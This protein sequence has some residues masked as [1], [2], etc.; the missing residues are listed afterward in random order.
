M[1]FKNNLKYF[2]LLVLLGFMLFSCTSNNPTPRPRAYFRIDFPEKT[3]KLFD[4]DCPF[5]FELPVYSFI[6]KEKE[7]KC[8]MDLYFPLNHAT[9]YMTYK[10]LNGDL[11][12]HLEDQ[13]EFV[14]KHV[15]KADAIEETGFVNDSLKVYGMLYYIKGNTA[16]S[17]QFYLT[18]SLNHFIRAS[19][20]FD[21]PPNKDSLAP[22]IQ[23]IRQDME[24]LM[25]TF[26]WK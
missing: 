25:E 10:T 23:F 21:V 15:V 20:Y 5:K 13:H 9:I 24:H 16:S 22:V 7:G 11:T 1:K 26:S 4:D 17:V 19:L 18:D 2:I 14:Y 8:W 12:S 6:I 3:Y